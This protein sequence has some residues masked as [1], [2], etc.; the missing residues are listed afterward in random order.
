MLNNIGKLRKEAGLTQRELAN[1]VGVTESTIANWEQGR[2]AKL[3]F[4]RVAKL[5]QDL[6][7]TPDELIKTER[8]Y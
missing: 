1:S 8:D 2:N 3:W 4:E 7:C 5:C 6:H